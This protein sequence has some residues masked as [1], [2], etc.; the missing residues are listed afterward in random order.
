MY[1]E[2][3]ILFLEEEIVTYLFIFKYNK[4]IVWVSIDKYNYKE[5]ETISLNVFRRGSLHM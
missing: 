2:W 4:F 1:S 3:S 5:V